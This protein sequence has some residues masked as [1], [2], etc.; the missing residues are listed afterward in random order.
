MKR[1]LV[2]SAMAALAACAFAQPQGPRPEGPRPDPQDTVKHFVF[3]TVD[4]VAITPVKNQK[5]AGTCWCYSGMGFLESEALK[6]TGK[7]F[8]FSEMFV[9][10]HTYMDRADKTVRTH[11][12]ASFS[13][14][15]SF[16]DITYALRNYG[17]V[18]DSEMPAGKMY[19]DTLSNHTE[20]S[21]MTDP[22][23]KAAANSRK[24]QFS[25]D[26]EPMWKK[27]VQAVHEIYLG[28]YP[29]TFTYEGK[30]FTP[31]TFAQYA[32]LDANDYVSLTSFTHHPYSEGDN[33]GVGFIIEVQDNWRWGTSLNLELDDFMAVIENAIKNGYTVLWG[34]DVSEPG[35]TRN[36][37]AV[38][39]DLKAEEV[40][41]MDQARWLKLDERARNQEIAN[42]PLPQK[43]V[44]A[45]ERQLGYDNFETT[46]DHGML[47]FGIAKDETGQLYY[48]VKNSWG[49][50]GK[51]NGIWYATPEFVRAKTLNYVV[52]K[53]AIPAEIRAKY[54]IDATAAPAKKGKK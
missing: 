27:A 54:G 37:I 24:L 8:D 16:C 2:V 17:L 32:Q 9:V 10:E 45:E 11:G 1:F 21:A 19:G 23:V 41:G 47:I 13:Q 22:M 43:K 15:G 25:P 14:G 52:N 53:A 7:T 29:E 40:P 31:K 49:T 33:K 36:G 34:A 20:L 5:N 4:S 39:P 12:D 50:T 28:K 6:K 18:P 26:G 44:T 42:R 38:Y 35:F 48:M 51:Y 30:Q 46:D 3:T